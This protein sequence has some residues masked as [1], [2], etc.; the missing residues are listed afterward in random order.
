[1]QA[2]ALAVEMQQ[3]RTRE[4]CVLAIFVDMCFDISSGAAADHVRF[5]LRNDIPVF[6]VVEQAYYETIKR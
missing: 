2:K 4:C 3:R 5:A 6:I 1:M